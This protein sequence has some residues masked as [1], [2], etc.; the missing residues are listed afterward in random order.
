MMSAIGND[1]LQ[2][3]LESAPTAHYTHCLNH[4][5]NFALVDAAKTVSKVADILDVLSMIKQIY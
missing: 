5:L 2:K 3:V 1:V 4:K